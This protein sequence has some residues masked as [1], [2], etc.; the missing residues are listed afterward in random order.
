M[1]EVK[2]TVSRFRTR[3]WSMAPLFLILEQSFKLSK[4]QFCP[5]EWYDNKIH[6]MLWGVNEKMHV[7]G[8]YRLWVGTQRMLVTTLA[9]I[10]NRYLPFLPSC[11]QPCVFLI[12]ISSVGSAF[13]WKKVCLQLWN[14]LR[15]RACGSFYF[16]LK[17]KKCVNM[18]WGQWWAEKI[19]RYVWSM[20]FQAPV[21]LYCLHKNSTFYFSQYYKE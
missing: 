13:P 16:K 19:W 17:I 10:I 1:G 14:Q 2:K 8:T 7:K 4:G 11:K 20:I 6:L 15:L 3:V 12:W 21:S 18:P 9:V 5:L